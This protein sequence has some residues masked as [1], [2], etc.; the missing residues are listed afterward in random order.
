[1]F[2]LAKTCPHCGAAQ[3]PPAAAPDAKPAAPK[4]IEITAEE[5]R[6]LLAAVPAREP[7]MRDVAE[8]LVLPRSGSVDLVLSLVAMPVTVLTV[9]VLGYA[10]LQAMRKKA[11]INLRGARLL[12][13]PTSA[14]FAALLLF[15]NDA[16]TG[17]WAALG[18]SLGAWLVRDVLRARARKDP[19]D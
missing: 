6:S 7:R 18:L 16:P 5:A 3:G 14:A 11:P 9:V 13:V 1:M 19:F 17:V 2:H 10:V 15:Q 4:K 12:A 8:D